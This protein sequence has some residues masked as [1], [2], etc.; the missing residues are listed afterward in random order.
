M[1]IGGGFVGMAG[2]VKVIIICV[3]VV[4]MVVEFLGCEDIIIGKCCLLNLIM[5]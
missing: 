1:F 4:V 3:F 2:G 5:C